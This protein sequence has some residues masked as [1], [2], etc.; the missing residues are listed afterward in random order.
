[1]YKKILKKI[2]ILYLILSIMLFIVILPY[3][4]FSSTNILFKNF[5]WYSSYILIEFILGV[6]LCI[7]LKIFYKENIHD[8]FKAV[9]ILMSLIMIIT[10]LIGNFSG[11]L[12]SKYYYFTAN[13]GIH[14]IILEERDY[15]VIAYKKN[16]LFV[17]KICNIYNDTENH[18]ILKNNYYKIEWN[19]NIM[20]FYY[21]FDDTKSIE[22]MYCVE[23]DSD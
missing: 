5:N 19:N 7:S 18:Y 4:L 14:Q 20:K 23:L 10:Q 21:A 6:N 22:K 12:K 1:M 3:M 9:L 2:K 16:G 13:D 15:T 8:E 11:G 17:K